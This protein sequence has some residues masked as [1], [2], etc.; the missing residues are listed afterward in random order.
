MD[1]SRRCEQLLYGLN[2]TKAE[3]V[4][5]CYE[6][7]SEV[8]GSERTLELAESKPGLFKEAK[9]RKTRRSLIPDNKRIK[10]SGMILFNRIVLLKELE[11]EYGK[12]R[13]VKKSTGTKSRFNSQSE[14]TN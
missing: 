13:S 5:V 6:H 12:I 14:T 4:H 7:V 11:N 1:P 9:R 8:I 10:T 2:R 3:E